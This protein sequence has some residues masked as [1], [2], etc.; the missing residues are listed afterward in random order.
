M[1]NETMIPVED[2]R[3]CIRDNNGVFIEMSPEEFMLAIQH[4]LGLLTN[5]ARAKGMNDRGYKKIAQYI[6]SL[7]AVSQKIRPTHLNIGILYNDR[8]NADR[9]GNSDQGNGIQDSGVEE[10]TRV[11]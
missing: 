3:I 6:G 9:S 4:G 2:N 7:S 11:D 8:S 5:Q 1:T 10:A